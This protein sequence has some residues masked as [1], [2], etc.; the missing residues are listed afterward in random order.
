MNIYTH[1]A[2]NNYTKNMKP[3][4][5][6]YYNQMNQCTK[7]FSNSNFSYWVES[8]QLQAQIRFIACQIDL[9]QILL[10]NKWREAYSQYPYKSTDGMIILEYYDQLGERGTLEG[11]ISYFNFTANYMTL[12]TFGGNFDKGLKRSHCVNSN[13]WSH[14]WKINEIPVPNVVTWEHPSIACACK[15]WKIIIPSKPGGI[16]NLSN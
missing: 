1:Q 9:C 6:S 7:V 10:L 12:I 3:N 11:N 5:L 8:S 16:L 2:V 14:N 15:S 13:M 4:D